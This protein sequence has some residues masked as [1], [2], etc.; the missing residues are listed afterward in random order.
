MEICR[1]KYICFS[2]GFAIKGEE[3][4]V[5]RLTKSLYG[6]KQYPKAWFDK[7]NK[8]VIAY[9]MKRCKVDHSVFNMH[10]S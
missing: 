3:S 5:Y 7:F 8:V 1:R 6:L 2:P 9:N 10:I 4:K